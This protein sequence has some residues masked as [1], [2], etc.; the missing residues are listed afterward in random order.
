MRKEDEFK[1]VHNVSNMPKKLR[2]FTSEQGHAWTY[3]DN[4]LLL[5]A[6]K[7]WLDRS[8]Q[9]I[10][11]WKQNTALPDRSFINF[12]FQKYFSTKRTLV[13]VRKHFF[14]L[15]QIHYGDKKRK[16]EEMLTL[17]E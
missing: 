10:I 15:K 3:R 7:T 9:E 14:K 4:E 6:Y 17:S 8:S 16:L 5:S 13:G 12:V 2:L 1:V 11:E